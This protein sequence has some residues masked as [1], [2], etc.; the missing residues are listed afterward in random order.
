MFGVVVVAASLASSTLLSPSSP[1]LSPSV[2]PPPSRHC[3]LDGRG[4]PTCSWCLSRINMEVTLVWE[5]HMTALPEHIRTTLLSEFIEEITEIT[6]GA[7][8]VYAFWRDCFGGQPF[9]RTRKGTEEHAQLWE[10][11]DRQSDPI[12][13]RR[14]LEERLA[15]TAASR[16]AAEAARA[17]AGADKA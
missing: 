14:A 8:E 12:R 17:A 2:A 9:F 5:D 6:L 10:T 7:T 16:A 3:V 4:T 11:L 15:R 1:S 13:K